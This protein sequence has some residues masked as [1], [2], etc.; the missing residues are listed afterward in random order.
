MDDT[1]A[2]TTADEIIG[3]YKR[4][5]NN[6][7]IGEEITQIEHACQSAQFAE[8]DGQDDE[9]VLAAFLHDLGHLLDEEANAEDMNGYGVKDH[10]ALGAEFLKAR[11]FPDKLALL[12]KSHVEAKR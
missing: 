11:G 12:I 1:Q 2:Q 10:E 7:Y 5:G 4:K 9:V 6:N 8:R 3:L